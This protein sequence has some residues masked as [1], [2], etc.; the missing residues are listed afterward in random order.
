LHWC[1]N[2]PILWGLYARFEELNLF[3][4]LVIVVEFR[5]QEQKQLSH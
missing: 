3:L 1:A 4:I 2:K 5:R